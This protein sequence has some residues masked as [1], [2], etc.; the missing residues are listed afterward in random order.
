MADSTTARSAS[1]KG[2]LPGAIRVSAMADHL[3][4]VAVR[5][6][7]VRFAI[8]LGVF[9]FGSAVLWLGRQA[10]R[11]ARRACASIIKMEK[12]HA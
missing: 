8:V 10:W 12:K 2:L 9:V 7:I 1:Q 11:C 5:F 4:T 3:A 6:A